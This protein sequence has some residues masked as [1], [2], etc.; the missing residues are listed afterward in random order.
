MRAVKK[1]GGGRKQSE[2]VSFRLW[3]GREQRDGVSGAVVHAVSEGRD[4]SATAA[5][6]AA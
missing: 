1:R 6:P 3:R 2:F 4:A 5:F